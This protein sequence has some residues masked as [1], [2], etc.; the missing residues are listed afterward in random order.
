[1]I[2]FMGSFQNKRFYNYDNEMLAKIV[3]C[4][5]NKCIKHVSTTMLQDIDIM[6]EKENWA[7]LVKRLLGS[8]GFQWS[9]VDTRGRQ[10]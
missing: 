2:L 10:C 8:F 6:P 1:M 7:V 4:N 9:L 5:E 3:L